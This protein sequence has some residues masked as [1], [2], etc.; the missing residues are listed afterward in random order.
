MFGS[1]TSVSS[2]LNI[3][4]SGTSADDL[5]KSTKIIKRMIIGISYL[6]NKNP[7]S[8]LR[9]IFGDEVSHSS[10]FFSMEEKNTKNGILVQYGKYEYIKNKKE[11]LGKDVNA[12]GYPYKE[13]GGLIFGEIDFNSYKK[14]FCTIANIKFKIT[15]QQF[16]L[17][18]FL[19]E[20]T[21]NKTWDY[22]SYSVKNQNCKDFVAE[23]IKILKPNYNENLI[24]ILDNSKVE[25][26]DDEAIIPYVILNELKRFYVKMDV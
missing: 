9:T 10:I 2:L 4:K 1:V 13:K 22:N 14:E 21:K 6:D 11:V 17:S 8:L 3:F 23:A 20:I 19:E 18:K 12:I 15:R 24:E 7:N 5:L 25:G 16:T 26:K